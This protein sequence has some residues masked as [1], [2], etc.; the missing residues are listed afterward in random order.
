MKD[1]QAKQPQWAAAQQA[2]EY[3]QSEPTARSW[4]TVRW[5][6]SD[7]ATQ[8]FRSYFTID[9]FLSWS[10]CSTRLP[11]ICTLQ[12]HRMAENELSRVTI[13]TGRRLRPK[14]WARRLGSVVTLQG[15]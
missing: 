12:L 13:Y 14:S 2:L 3:A 15:L 10:N 8:L 1:F 9:K 4:N 7:A 6:L 5:A 11:L